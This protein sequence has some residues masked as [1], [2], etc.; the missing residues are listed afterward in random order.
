MLLED[1][2]PITK[3]WYVPEGHQNL[4]SSDAALDNG[5]CEF[6]DN[7]IRKFQNA[8]VESVAVGIRNNSVYRLL[9][10]MLISESARVAV[11][12]YNLQLWHRRMGHQHKS[13][14][15]NFMK[16]R[17]RDVKPDNEFC[18]AC[19]FGKMHR[20]SFGSRQN[21]PKCAGQLVPTC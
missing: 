21:R 2:N 20:L 8:L 18:D 7:E 16:H 4:F 6:A 5:L 13:H 1:G 15:K 3:V 17:D 14:V 9:M 11:D 10:W 19:M 12:K